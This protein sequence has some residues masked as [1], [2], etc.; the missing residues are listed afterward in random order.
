[1]SFSKRRSPRLAAVAVWLRVN[2]AVLLTAGA[3]LAG[4]LL[5]TFAIAGVLRPRIV[6]PTSLGLLALSAAGWNLVGR[7]VFFGLYDISRKD[8]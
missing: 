7:V 6:W 4:W 3:M 8:S 1:M 2:R 5:L